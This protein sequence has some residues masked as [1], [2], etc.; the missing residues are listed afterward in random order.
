[1]YTTGLMA[2]GVERYIQDKLL[3]LPED[4][5]DIPFLRAQLQ[6]FSAFNVSKEVSGKPEFDL[7]SEWVRQA[8]I[9]TKK[10]AAALNMAPDEYYRSL[11]RFTEKPEDSELHLTVPLI[12][13]TRL[14]WEK[15]AELAGVH[16]YLWGKSPL[17]DISPEK[18]RSPSTPYTTWAQDGTL[19]VNIWADD[20]RKRL[21]KKY[22]GANFYE[23]IAYHLARPLPDTGGFGFELLGSAAGSDCV[24]TINNCGGTMID[25]VIKFSKDYLPNN[26]YRA[27]VCSP[28]VRT[29]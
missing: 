26:G 9:L 23:G 4:H 18:F 20:A 29:S 13:E 17:L 12:V 28:Q 2:L 16:I 7:D 21:G 5:P 24:P 19:F 15:V 14:P 11:P 3:E 22:R 10:F 6:V 27:L 1:M 8:K 25:R